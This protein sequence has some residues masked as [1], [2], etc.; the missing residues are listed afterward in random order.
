MTEPL[1]IVINHETMVEAFRVAKERLGLSNEFCDDIGGL[2]RGHTDKILGPTRIKNLGPMTMDVFCEMFAVKFIM[3]SNIEAAKRMEPRW[4]GRESSH[5]RT[6]SVRVSKAIIE[7]AK[8]HVLKA[9]GSAGGKATQAMR[10]ASHRSE[11]GRRAAKIRWRKH[12]KQAREAL[13]RC[14][15]A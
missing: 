3:V 7:R 6:E 12:R 2:T 13:V 14:E 8:S 1:A 10:S 15:P 5:V 4:E 9:C 11:A